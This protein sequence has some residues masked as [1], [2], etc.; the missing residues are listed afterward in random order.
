[1]REQRWI[2]PSEMEEFVG[3]KREQEEWE[4]THKARRQ[5]RKHG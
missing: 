3:G 1:M 2:G 4:S 5:V